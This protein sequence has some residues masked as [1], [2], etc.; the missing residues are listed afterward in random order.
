MIDLT[1]AHFA[2]RPLYLDRPSETYRLVGDAVA[3]GT[4]VQV[5]VPGVTLDLDGHELVYGDESPE[6]GYHGV[7]ATGVL[8]ITIRN[9][10]IRQGRG[11]GPKCHPICAVALSNLTIDG[12]DLTYSGDD[13]SGVWTQW[14]NGVA[15]TN[16]RIDGS[17][18]TKVSNRREP[19]AGIRIADATGKATIRNNRIVGVPHVGIMYN[20]RPGA[21]SLTVEGNDIRQ[22]SIATNGYGILLAGVRNGRIMGNTVLPVNGRG[23][24]IDGWGHIPTEDLVVER[25]YFCAFEDASLNAEYPWTGLEATALR[26]RCGEGEKPWCNVTVRRNTCGAW[27]VEGGVHQAI[28]CR[29]SYEGQPPTNI[30]IHD[31]ALVGI[32]HTSDSRYTATG[33]SVSRCAAKGLEDVTITSNDCVSNV[34]GIVIGDRDGWQKVIESLD[35]SENVIRRI[36]AYERTFVPLEIGGGEATVRDVSAHDLVSQNCPQAVVYPPGGKVE[37]VEVTWL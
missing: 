8:D 20:G 1:P 34:C 12:V 14:A 13:C 6:T 25:N 24:L 9:G 32:A 18:V 15:V 10:R 3:P 16:C 33:L 22:R 36:Y 19:V 27:T 7:F 17:G 35:L 5:L 31:N 2:G 29:F 37:G 23:L 4:A 21:E 30:R 26:L 28:G 11:R